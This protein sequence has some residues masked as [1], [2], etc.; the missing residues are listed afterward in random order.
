MFSFFSQPAKVKENSRFENTQI[1]TDLFPLIEQLRERQKILNAAADKEGPQSLA[2]RKNVLLLNVLEIFDDRIA[3]FN[4]QKIHYKEDK[5]YNQI[6][7]LVDDLFKPIE[8][9]INED[10][11]LT[12]ERDAKKREVI[13]KTTNIA[14]KL[15]ILR[16][17]ALGSFNIVGGIAFFLGTTIITSEVRSYLGLLAHEPESSK[18][19]KNMHGVLKDLRD[20][21]G[22]Y[23]DQNLI[24]RARRIMKTKRTLTA[25]AL[26]FMEPALPFEAKKLIMLY[27]IT[28]YE[29]EEHLQRL[30]IYN[31]SLLQ[32]ANAMR[33]EY[34]D[35]KLLES[36]HEEKRI[37]K[38]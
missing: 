10:D 2:F 16:Y 28:G 20:N 37:A 36:L 25:I 38:P 23:L 29:R 9:I 15:A 19:I 24:P 6:Y 12:L 34:Q 7:F 3:N 17:I 14:E 35:R 18:I 33:V 30:D 26:A 32:T 22:N 31:T 21:L 27:M 4:S 1:L 8:Q 5:E 11:T 13:G